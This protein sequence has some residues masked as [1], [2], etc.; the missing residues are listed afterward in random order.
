MH[1]RECPGV[2]WGMWAGS[3]WVMSR[4]GRRHDP[5]LVARAPTKITVRADQPQCALT[6]SAR[7]IQLGL[8]TS[9]FSAQKT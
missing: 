4:S 6:R 1:G 5:N 3:F 8:G 7:Y 2:G 9:C